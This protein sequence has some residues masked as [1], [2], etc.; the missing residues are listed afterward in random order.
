MTRRFDRAQGDVR[1][2]MQTLCAMAHLDYKL[3]GTH[4]YA[5][6]FG[7]MRELQLP[8]KDQ[9]EAFR[10]M[11]FNVMARNCEHAGVPDKEIRNRERQLLLL[12]RRSRRPT[13]TAR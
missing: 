12:P 5:Q 10:R 9:E 6:L 1:H 4:S 13:R 3:K 8:Y 7:T 2:H 11:V